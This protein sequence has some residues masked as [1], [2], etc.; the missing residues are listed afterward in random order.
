MVTIDQAVIVRSGSFWIISSARPRTVIGRP[1]VYSITMPAS[2]RESE[3]ATEFIGLVIG[4]QGR[5]ITSS[6]GQVPIVPAIAS[7]YG[8][9]HILL[10]KL[11]IV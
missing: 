8:I 4:G 7:G 9:P 2:A 6:E 5:A 11:Q 10:P 1:L 3:G